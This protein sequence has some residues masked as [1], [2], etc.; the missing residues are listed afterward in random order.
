MMMPPA[1]AT[2]RPRR[3]ALIE[4]A[5]ERL[6]QRLEAAA[7]VKVADGGQDRDGS[8]AVLPVEHLRDA[9]AIDA[10]ELRPNGTKVLQ[11]DFCAPVECVS[12]HKTALVGSSNVP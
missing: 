8:A 9:G 5:L 3:I 6:E 7:G 10:A 11:S 2:V 12:P 1:G 4:R